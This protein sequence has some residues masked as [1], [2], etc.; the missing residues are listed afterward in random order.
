M[1]SPSLPRFIN[2][3]DYLAPGEA[4]TDPMINELFRPAGF[5]WASGFIHELPHGDLAV[6]NLEQFY[7]RGPIRG[8]AL[9][10]LNAIYP[11]LARGA[12][13]AARSEFER[14]KNAVET[15]ATVGLPAAAMTP[16]GRVVVANDAFATAA[17]VWTTRAG[18]RLGLHDRVADAM[19][20]EALAAHKEARG[21]RSIP[22]RAELGGVITGVVQ[23][24]PIRRAA[25]DI[26]G[27]STALVILSELKG[28]AANATLIQSLF[29]LTPAEI[30]VAQAIAAGLSVAQIAGSGGRS[31]ATVRNQLRSAMSK[32]GSSRQVELAL[33][34]RQ[35]G[36]RPIG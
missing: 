32:T 17:H 7:D 27:S 4:E 22:L 35:L 29:D 24:V 1:W 2:E 3:D 21:Q 33:L 18:N 34:M 30:A 19:L 12:M 26:F 14:V 20:A 11:H 9:A 15:L 28:Q 5:G 16:T 23:V 13:F 25:H 6:L 31:V 10:R 36:S 8:D